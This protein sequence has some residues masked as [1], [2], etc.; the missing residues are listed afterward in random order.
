MPNQKA[1]GPSEICY[2]HIK[3]AS[4]KA[5]SLFRNF[6]NKCFQLQTVPTEWKSS[7]IFLI[8]KKSNWDLTLNQVRPISII[9]LF[10]K[11]FTKIFT[12]R[13]DQIISS[14]NLLSNLNFTASKNLS[15]HTPIQILHNTI[16]H[17]KTHNKEA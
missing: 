8:P 4:S 9:E 11:I 7:N 14:N 6:L 2:E 1:A 16:K 17:Y 15:T 10:K 12:N 3:Y 5:Q 13:L